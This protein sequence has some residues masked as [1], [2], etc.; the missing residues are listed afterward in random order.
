M[1]C[2]TAVSYSGDPGSSSPRPLCSA[3]CCSSPSVTSPPSNVATFF[4]PE[5]ELA[6][7]SAGWQPAS[8]TVIKAHRTKNALK[9]R[10]LL[11]AT[12]TSLSG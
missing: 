11:K 2:W 1:T 3:N 7:V 5:F 10:C 9:D 12:G 8:T 6:V 4:E